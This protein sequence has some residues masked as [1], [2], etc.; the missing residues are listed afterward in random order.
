MNYINTK[1][2]LILL[3]SE[4]IVPGQDT[5]LGPEYKDVPMGTMFMEYL[6][7]H[8]AVIGLMILSAFIFEK[9]INKVKLHPVMKVLSIIAE[10]TLI[11]LPPLFIYDLPQIIPSIV[12][13]VLLGLLALILCAICNLDDKNISSIRKIIVYSSIVIIWSMRWFTL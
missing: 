11:A 13:L 10:I 4:K 9:L 3:T 1:L 6:L 2:T 7:V 12:L 8:L 5:T